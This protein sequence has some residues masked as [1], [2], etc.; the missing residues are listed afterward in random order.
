MGTLP[1]LTAISVLLDSLL[2]CYITDFILRE[3]HKYLREGDQKSLA[4]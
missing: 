4:V 1:I 3:M 2:S